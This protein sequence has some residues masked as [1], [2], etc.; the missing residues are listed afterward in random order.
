M[1]GATKQT[2]LRRNDIIAKSS[3]YWR[4][5]HLIKQHLSM[6]QLLFLQYPGTFTIFV[7]LMANGNAFVECRVEIIAANTQLFVKVVSINYIFCKRI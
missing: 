4:V 7:H 2:S 5:G 6:Q 3:G 1:K